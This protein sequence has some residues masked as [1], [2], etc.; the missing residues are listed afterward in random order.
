MP[1]TAIDGEFALPRCACC[2]GT[3]TWLMDEP[4]VDR[5]GDRV[6]LI[7]CEDCAALAGLYA[8]PPDALAAQVLHH[9]ELWEAETRESLLKARDDMGRML[10]FHRR[11]LPDRTTEHCV[12]DIGSGRGNLLAAL[13]Q[14]GYR[15]CGCEPSETLVQRARLVYGLDE[16]A[17][18][19]CTAQAFLDQLQSRAGT[20]DTVFLWHVLEHMLAP[21]ALL[22]RLKL[23]LRP[24]GTLICQGP[25][26]VPANLFAQHLF[27]HTEPNIRWIARQIGLVVRYIDCRPSVPGFASFVLTQ[28]GWVPVGAASQ[29]TAVSGALPPGGVSGAS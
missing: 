12:L 9:A 6:P 24:G 1:G 8:A 21:M 26:L 5:D 2:G 14:Q 18:A 17:L 29:T 23:L 25:M 27:L 20:V 22:G 16:S 15:A 13:R 7:R 11:F 3:R 28:P 19:G 10:E 4:H